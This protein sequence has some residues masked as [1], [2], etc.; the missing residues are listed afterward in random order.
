MQKG[1]KLEVVETDGDQALYSASFVA[2]S[3]EQM[4]LTFSLDTL[5]EMKAD[6][7]AERIR[8]KWL[9]VKL[10]TEE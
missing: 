8:P 7:A 9:D 2:E 1:I 10:K 4:I 6:F 5:L 3:G